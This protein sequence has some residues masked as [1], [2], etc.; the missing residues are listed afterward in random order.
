MSAGYMPLLRVAAAPRSSE[1]GGV[2]RW[3][4]VQIKP[5]DILYVDQDLVAVDKPSGVLC[6][7]TRD[8]DRDHL[9]T[10]LAR[11]SGDDAAVFL[12]VHRLD[13]G[14]SGV[15]VFARNKPVATALMEQ[16]QQRAV[17]KLYQAVVAGS[18]TRAWRLGH[19]FER[20]SF[21]RHHKGRSE[22]VRSGGKPAHTRFTVINSSG[23][24][25]LVEA[26]P[27]T[28]R[29]H[30]LRVHLAGVG[31]PIFGDD[32]YGTSAHL[33]TGRLWL[34][35]HTLSFTHPASEQ[36]LTIRSRTELALENGAPI[37]VSSHH[38]P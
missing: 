14:T 17:S 37:Q 29:T 20:R 12:P 34:H 16:F 9:G 26:A 22:E 11:W 13:L 2:S 21:L 28:G 24:L 7:A 15:V 1:A 23:D 19:E 31:A 6:D 3:P 10:A 25:A 18:G 38:C 35:A 33:E 36:L 27:T 8:P 4:T 5:D 32:R 30:Q